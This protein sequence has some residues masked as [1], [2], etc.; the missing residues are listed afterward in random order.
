MPSLPKLQAVLRCAKGGDTAVLWTLNWMERC[1]TLRPFKAAY[2]AL[3][4]GTD[5]ALFLSFQSKKT[6]LSFL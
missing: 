4:H 6:E 2:K 1:T 3:A 5:E